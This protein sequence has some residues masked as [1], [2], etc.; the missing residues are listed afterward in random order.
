MSEVLCIFSSDAHGRPSDFNPPPKF[1]RPNFMFPGEQVEGA[2]PSN[3]TTNGSFKRNGSTYKCQDGTSCA[4]PIAA[5]VAAGVLEFAWQE[6]EHKI[7]KAKMLKHYR[8]M[9]GVFMRRMVDDH[10]VGDNS[11]HYVKPWKL[12]SNGRPKDEIPILLS[13]T[14]DSV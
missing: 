3:V 11:R 1:D 10:K 8:G 2:W 12:I 9:S 4:T 14:M 7:R 6:R 5:A 13:D